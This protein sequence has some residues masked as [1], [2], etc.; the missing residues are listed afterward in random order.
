MHQNVQTST[1]YQELRGLYLHINS[2]NYSAYL[3]EGTWNGTVWNIHWNIF[4]FVQRETD[5]DDS[6]K[7]KD[8][9]IIIS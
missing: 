3:A 9:I 8:A 4:D 2:T 7:H 5:M 6:R 1:E